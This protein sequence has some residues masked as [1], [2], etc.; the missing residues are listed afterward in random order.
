V[1]CGERLPS[2]RE[3]LRAADKHC[4]ESQPLS[5]IIAGDIILLFHIM[6]NKDIFPGEIR[7]VFTPSPLNFIYCISAFIVHG[8]FLMTFCHGVLF[9]LSY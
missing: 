5:L 1:C 6:K 3:Y 8:V 7:F 9:Y 2:A 4:Q